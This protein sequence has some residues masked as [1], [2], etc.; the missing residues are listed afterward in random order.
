GHGRGGGVKLG[1]P[2]RGRLRAPKMEPFV[3]LWEV[4]MFLL[5]MQLIIRSY[6]AFVVTLILFL[7][8]LAGTYKFWYKNLP[9]EPG[10]D[11]HKTVVLP[12]I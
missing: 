3:F 11:E 5:P 7:I 6:Q 12:E 2:T 10:K 4:T 1:G 8:G 9:P